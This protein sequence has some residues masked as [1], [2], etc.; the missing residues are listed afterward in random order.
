MG[1]LAIRGG[2]PVRHPRNPW[3]AW[4]PVS[5]R[6]VEL[7][8]EVIRS[9]TWAFDGPKE[10]EFARA[11]ADFSGARYCVPV[12]N[13]TVAVQ[14][15]LEALDI[16]AYDE[17]IVPGLTWQAT[18]AACIDVNAV[19]VL[20]DVDPETWCMDAARAE[21]AI[22]P[23]TRALIAVHL[24]GSMPDMDA[25]RD[26]AHRRKLL[27]LEDCAHQHGAR[28][29]GKAVGTLGSIGAFSLQQSKV[30][31][32]GEGGLTLTDDW[33]L[34]QR[35]YSLR[36]CG[37]PFQS[38]APTVQSGNYRM[39]DIQAALLLAQMDLME[40]RVERRD[41]NGRYLA[42]R[43]AEVPGI[44]PMK[45]HGRVT[46]GS[47]YCYSFR[48]DPSAWDGIP[49]AAFHKALA[50]ETG[51]SIGSTYEPL[52][53]SPLYRPHTKKRHHLNE[54]YWKA[55]D[56]GRFRLPVAERAY[57]EEAVVIHHPFLLAERS[58]M[59]SI[60]EAAAKIHTHR[61]ELRGIA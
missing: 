10:W 4:P 22:T 55:I 12:A 26:L 44:K 20:V 30:L 19:P 60:A 47:Y 38:G 6:A 35:L 7:V 61:G 39:T 24:Y 16:G 25:L 23:R 41:A 13:G 43:L 42:D 28:W 27:L 8:T 40:E 45:R 21:E 54:D 58:D 15:A 46:R 49:V 9:G 31:T 2:E 14:L 3:P 36:N 57:R 17:V 52:N 48:Y 1:K 29:D 59:D 11:F 32:S 51:L 50:A 5:D 33:T 18:A 34:F 37:R 56:P 53:D